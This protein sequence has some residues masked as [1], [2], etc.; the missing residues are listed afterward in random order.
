MRLLALDISASPGF[1]VIEV[2]Q[3]K[4]GP[5]I[6]LVFADSI[7]TDASIPDS[8]R[9]SYIEA[10]TALI[11]HEYGP[12]DVV[13]REH[14]TKGRSKRSTQLVFGAWAAV[15]MALGRYGYSISEENEFTPTT[16]KKSVAGNGGADKLDVENGV[17]KKLG[18]PNDFIFKSDDASDAVAVGIT[19][20]QLKGGIS[21]E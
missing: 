21:L 3:L 18:I 7:K 1:A 15:D 17:R 8:R 6:S 4:A 16:V 11:L 19:Y 9:Y 20:L 2:K 5:K 12:F 10:K 13:C 14:F